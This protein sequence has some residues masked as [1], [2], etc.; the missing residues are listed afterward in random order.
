MDGAARTTFW[1]ELK[2]GLVAVVSFRWGVLPGAKPEFERGLFISNG[3]IRPLNS[4][5][6]YDFKTVRGTLSLSGAEYAL[7]QDKSIFRVINVWDRKKRKWDL[8]RIEPL[9]QTS[10]LK[11]IKPDVGPD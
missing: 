1:L 6:T 7:D 5:L 8:S 11:L 9:L 2:D 10:P 4:R 3:R